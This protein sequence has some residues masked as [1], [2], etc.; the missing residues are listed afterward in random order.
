MK[1][2]TITFDPGDLADTIE[3]RAEAEGVSVSE[4]I[5][6]ALRMRLKITSRKVLRV[7]VVDGGRR[8]KV[9]E[10]RG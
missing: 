1:R 9:G 10:I 8:Y 2:R 7:E 5:R 3:K 6:D 4:L